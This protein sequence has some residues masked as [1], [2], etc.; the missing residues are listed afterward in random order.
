MSRPK[1]QCS[2][3]EGGGKRL[4]RRKKWRDASCES[5]NQLTVETTPHKVIINTRTTGYR[6]VSVWRK[7]FF[8]LRHIVIL[9]SNSLLSFDVTYYSSLPRA[10][11]LSPFVHVSREERFWSEVSFDVN[12]YRTELDARQRGRW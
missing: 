7:K 8:S 12:V 3:R 1:G 6:S 2:T 10:Q 5:H 11:N 4:Y 9:S